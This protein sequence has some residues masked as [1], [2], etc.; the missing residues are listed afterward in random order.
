MKKEFKI[1]LFRVGLIKPNSSMSNYFT[2]LVLPVANQLVKNNFQVYFHTYFKVFSFPNI[3]YLFHKRK[4]IFNIIGILIDE[5]QI[6]FFRLKFKNEVLII[7][8]NQ[9][10]PTI[11]SSKFSLIVIHDVIPYEFKNYFFLL[12]LFY[13]YYLN[14]YCK[15][16]LHVITVSDTSNKKISNYFNIN[17]NKITT[18]YNGIKFSKS[19]TKHTS[20]SNF[21]SFLYVGADLPHKNLEKLADAFL[22]LSDK[23]SLRLV[24]SCC[25]NKKILQLNAIRPKNIFLLNSLSD[26]QL[27]ELY[28]NSSALIFPSLSEGFGLPL[29]EAMYYGLPIL[30]SNKDFALEVCKDYKN[31]IYF[32]P[33]NTKS[34]IDSIIDFSNKQIEKIPF[35][36]LIANNSI[37]SKYSWAN[38]QK[39]LLN[40]ISSYLK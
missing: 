26:E 31:T 36:N 28:Q 20:I 15:M 18:I 22:N 21:D 3:P 1:V 4:S 5:F 13:K 14:F 37:I 32:D 38:S 23:Y 29:V 7:N 10:L 25:K 12:H 34:L 17:S 40:L 11:L 33:N 16:A 6:L 39:K 27:S 8:I 30:V 35:E 2:N 24:G 9:L 19:L